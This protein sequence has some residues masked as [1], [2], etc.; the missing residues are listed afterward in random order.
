MDIVI[1]ATVAFFFVFLLTRITGRRNLSVLEPFDLILIVMLGDLVQQGVTQSDYS[2]TGMILAAGTIGVLSVAISY[3]GY[4]FR[5][6]RPA[7]EGEPIVVIQDGEVLEDNL[8]GQRIT[9]AELAARARLQQLSSF[10]GVQWAIL[11][12]GGQISFIP[13]K[14]S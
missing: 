12:K 14:T 3:A 1:R 9:R 11:E 2:L 6:L 7:L 5:V 4:R 10:E 13:K 8:R